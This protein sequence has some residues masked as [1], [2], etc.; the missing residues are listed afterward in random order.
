[1]RK[2]IEDLYFGKINPCET[3]KMEDPFFM[4][5]TVK[6]DKLEKKLDAALKGED[7]Q[8]FH[9]F[10]NLM[11]EL[12][13]IAETGNFVAGFKLGVKLSIEALYDED[14]EQIALSCPEK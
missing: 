14:E 5:A 2:I 3:V 6:L 1:M 9:D 11:D 4:T 8:L 7:L 13:G 12:R 10:V